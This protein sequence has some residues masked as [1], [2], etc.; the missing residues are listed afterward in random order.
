MTS[1]RKII[2]DYV[3]RMEGINEKRMDAAQRELNFTMH[4]C[5]ALN[6]LRQGLLVLDSIKIK[7]EEDGISED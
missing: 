2:D 4:E 1:L 7:G 6:E 5:K 3:K